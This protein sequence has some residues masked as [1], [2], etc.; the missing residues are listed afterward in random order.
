[1]KEEEEDG[2]M[3]LLIEA[4]Q[5]ELENMF[6]ESLDNPSPYDLDGSQR[7]DYLDFDIMGND[8]G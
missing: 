4:L 7:E 5:R 3:D 2:L 1:M 8:N 6:I